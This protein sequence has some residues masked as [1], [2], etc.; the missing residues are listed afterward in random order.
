MLSVAFPGGSALDDL[1]HRDKRLSKIGKTLPL[2]PHAHVERHQEGIR[3]H[4]PMT[5]T[6]CPLHTICSIPAGIPFS[7]PYPEAGLLRTPT[8]ASSARWTVNLW[9]IRESS[10]PVD[11]DGCLWTGP[12]RRERNADPTFS[13][14]QE[15]VTAF[16]IYLQQPSCGLTQ[17]LW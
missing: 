10:T 15:P 6:A 7:H 11:V 3:G 1:G 9:D 14:F 13:I 17:F 12:W 2:Q 5:T 4:K 8:D 16:L